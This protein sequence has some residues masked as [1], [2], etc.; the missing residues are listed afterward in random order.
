MTGS[1][2]PFETPDFLHDWPLRN[3]A[4]AY[5]YFNE[6]ALTMAR[7][8]ADKR[9]HTPLAIGL[10]GPWG[11]GKTTLM[12]RIRMMLDETRCFDHD[13]ADLL[14][15]CNGEE[16]PR[17][18]FRICRTVWFDA[19]KYTGEDHILAALL[20]AIVNRMKEE[21]FIERVKAAL[22]GPKKEE[23]K[24]VGVVLNAL[25]GYASAGTY[26][27]NLEEFRVDTEFKTA[28]A[29]FDYFDASLTRLIASWV[30]G[31]VFF[32][33]PPDE[34]K[35]IMV[36]FIDDLDRCLPKKTVEVLE[37]IKLF[38]DKSGCAFV[39]G[40]DI[41]VIR[42]AVAG[43]YKEAGLTPE[44][45]NDYLEKVIQLRFGL[46]PILS[47]VMKTYL[48]VERCADATIL[49]NWQVLMAGADANPRRVKAIINEINLQWA[50]LR[51]T[52]QAE[53]VNRGD[54]VRWNILS[55]AAPADFLQQLRDIGDLDSP[56]LQKK[57]IDDILAWAVGGSAE[58]E[59]QFKQY[60][61]SKRFRM[62]L[63]AI[64]SF[65]DTFDVKALNSFLYLA[66]PP[67]LPEAAGAAAEVETA[68]TT[69]GAGKP[70]AAALRPEKLL[71]IHGIPF[72]HIPKGEFVMGS[73]A[74]NPQAYEDEQPQKSVNIPYDYWIGRYPVTNEQFAEFAREA[75]LEHPSGKEWKKREN[76]PVI[77]VNWDTAR[78]FCQWLAEQGSASLP[79]GYTIALPNE[80]E[81]EKAARGLYGNEWP[82]GNAFDPARCNTAEG[83]AGGTTPV[84]KYS[85]A[86]DSPF[87]CADMAGDVWEWTR[88]AL[89]KYPYDPA[90]GREDAG[91]TVPRVVR[92][93]S[94]YDNDWYARCAFR[95]QNGPAD[96]GGNLGFRV[97]LLPSSTLNSG[98]SE[99]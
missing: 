31:D 76:H 51:N 24:W 25:T 4:K 2:F 49:E 15:F 60:L 50:I 97:V 43:H 98:S 74:D 38:L 53:Q 77:N 45:A 22:S 27:L 66:V 7:L 92:G 72:A 89:A 11:S 26:G 34:E 23:I 63:R 12:K 64:R 30:H 93:G 55:S 88:S 5:F 40:A 70:E 68:P 13:S 78:Q 42:R 75:K 95:A 48:E 44:S 9:T 85:P 96:I 59:Q 99:L 35:G 73:R 71:E 37:A 6:Y 46:P 20:R 87:G 14:T 82:W 33:G 61:P 3:D 79:P 94:W 62:V 80:P 18:I 90:D 8:I 81:W 39:L 21:G 16:K 28:S 58:S 57:Y 56:E 83:G 32:A 86:G 54:F 65:S 19:W 52:R 84:G 91:K 1:D 41:D 47:D 29:F 17:E 69:A 10:S 67:A 36:I